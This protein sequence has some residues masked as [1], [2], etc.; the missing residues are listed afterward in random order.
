MYILYY[1]REILTRI[2][3]IEKNRYILFEKINEIRFRK[4]NKIKK[5]V[6]MVMLFLFGLS[7]IHRL[8]A[9][10]ENINFAKT[11]GS[12]FKSIESIINFLIQ[13]LILFI[14]FI[15]ISYLIKKIIFY[16]VS[17]IDLS[18]EDKTIINTL[19]CNIKKLDIKREKLLSDLNNSC[20]PMNYRNL[21]A[22]NFMIK[23]YEN[24]QGDTF[25][26]LVNLYKNY[27][28]SN[29][30]TNE[31]KCK[32]SFYEQE[33][34]GLNRDLIKI[35]NEIRRKQS[36]YKKEINSLN[37]DLRKIQKDLDKTKKRFRQN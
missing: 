19:K 24:K 34:N 28:I 32:R 25:E 13:M 27:I 12:F 22:I 16:M 20:I 3:E 4:A 6:F 35:Q 26:E 29:K 18:E 33:I 14:L 21:N 23:S 17:K 10:N 15:L 31:I 1:T 8:D 9:L 2:N 37:K 5:R 30:F 36:F 7:T 11:Q